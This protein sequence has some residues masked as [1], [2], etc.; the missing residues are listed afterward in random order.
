MARDI[1]PKQEEFCLKFIE[2]GSAADAYIVAYKKPATYNRKSAAQ[3]G[4]HML[5]GA[6]VAARIAELRAQHAEDQGVTVKSIADQLDEDRKFARENG[7]PAA[8]VSA[9][10]AKGKLYGHFVD[11]K[12]ITIGMRPDEARQII[13]ALGAKL[14]GG[15]Q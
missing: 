7:V 11:K 9:T 12:D 5:K 15:G 8:A 2:L 4:S 3:T 14:L 13:A 10:I 1:T 6:R